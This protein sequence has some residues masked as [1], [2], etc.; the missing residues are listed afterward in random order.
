MISV[1]FT[2]KGRPALTE[3]CLRRFKELMPEPYE[4]FICYNGMDE[5][6][7]DKLQLLWAD[8]ASIVFG[9]GS[10]FKLI[11]EALDDAEGDYFMHLENDFYWQ[12]RKCLQ[13]SLEFLQRYEDLDYIRFEYLPFT[14][15]TFSEYR[16]I[17][18][19]QIGVMKKDAPYQFTFNPHLRRD[20]FPCGR[21]QEDS[22]TKQP[23]QHHNDTY[24][25]TSAC[26]FGNNFRH[27]GIYD[28]GGHYKP[29]Y[30]E[31]L[32]LRRG[33]RTID[34]PLYEFDQFCSNY[35][36]RQLFMRYL[37]DNRDKHNKKRN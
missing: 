35:L 18:D 29:W 5:D 9:D 6:Y 7:M 33:E 25:G 10:R 14:E 3:L 23:E 11:N 16:Q 26:L 1:V 30:A 12:R 34:R 21:F 13:D 8:G 22:F 20:K 4:L 37:H 2:C 31:R 17:E 27:L 24:K 19:N 28:E 36:Y 32:T 15:K